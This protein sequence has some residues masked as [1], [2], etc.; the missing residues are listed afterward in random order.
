MGGRHSMSA[1]E[2]RTTMNRIEKVVLG[3][4][5]LLTTG[6][7]AVACVRAGRLAAAARR[8]NEA[9]KAVVLRVAPAVAIGNRPQFRG[10]A[11]APY[12]LVEFMDYQ[13]PPCKAVH[14]DLPGLVSRYGP[15]VRYTI[16]QF[17]LVNMHPFAM[18]AAIASEAAREQGRFWEMHDGLMDCGGAP[19][20][21]A[22]A[23][24]AQRLHMD[25]K[26]FAQ[27]CRT[28]ARAAVHTDLAAA[29]AL[30]LP[31]TPSFVLCSPG[32]RVVRLGSLAQIGR[33]IPGG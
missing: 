2:S 4:A 17:P 19:D 20:A 13:C 10:A 1:I 25:A 3:S 15:R 22:I 27:A 11:G 16:R 18:D 12:V 29:S 24:L 30:D 14:A 9:K 26:R 8:Q 31:G 5:L 32:G 33:F 28:T 7:V 21:A 23:D 6:L